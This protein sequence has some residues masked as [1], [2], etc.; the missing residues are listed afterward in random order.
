MEYLTVIPAMILSA[1]RKIPGR[2][3]VCLVFALGLLSGSAANADQLYVLNLLSS[4][5]PVDTGQLPPLAG[6]PDQ[7][8]YI[9]RETI[10]GKHW[11]RLRLGFFE[12]RALA[13][14]ARQQ[15]EEHYPGAWIATA[16]AKEYQ[17]VNAGTGALPALTRATDGKTGTAD[18]AHTVV[19]PASRQAPI[20]IAAESSNKEDVI[21]G[22]DRLPPPAAGG[23]KSKGYS[24]DFDDPPKARFELTPDLSFGAKLELEAEREKDFDLDSDRDRDEKTLEPILSLVLSYTPTEDLLAYLNIEPSRRFIDDDR[25]RKDHETRLEV[26]QAFLSYSS[27]F[28]GSTIKLGR[29][30]FQDEREWLYDD[31]LDGVRLFHTF[32]RFAAE[33]S[34]SKRGDRDLLNDQNPDNIVNYIINGRYAPGKDNEIGLYAFAQDDREDSDEDLLFLGLHADGEAWDQLNYWLE[35]A[36]LWGDAGSTD[37]RAYGA[38]IGGTFVFDAPLDPSITLGYAYG[39]GD[40]DPDDSDDGNF[41]QTGF[42][43]NAAKFN[44]L[45]RLRYYGEMVDPELSN[46]QI[47]TAGIGIRPT[48]NTSLDLVYHDYTQVEASDDVRDWQIKDDPDGRND[49]IGSAIDFIAGYRFKPHHKGSLIIGHFDPG[50][51]FPDD[52]D[53]ALY[54]ELELQYEF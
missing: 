33:F 24:F 54:V 25:D 21:P 34:V 39:S 10:D 36:Y 5:P 40:D 2:G 30:R 8:A 3:A 4:R 44:G 47:A 6:Y 19:M 14:T 7:Q 13:N 1:W 29:Q 20:T 18:T 9:T 16:S 23:D 51:A 42:Q 50:D 37:I 35:I 53:D 17:Q 32:S 11:H 41:R 12:D 43:D 31:E 26:K 27:L 38:D 46:L 28:G 15:V 48:R 45:I 49:D 22:V 52:S